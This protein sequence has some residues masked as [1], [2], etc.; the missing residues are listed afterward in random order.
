MMIDQDRYY[1]RERWGEPHGQNSDAYKDFYYQDGLMDLYK[2]AEGGAVEFYHSYIELAFHP[3]VEFGWGPGGFR[4]DTGAAKGR[5][6]LEAVTH[7]IRN[8]NPQT[9]A[10]MG[11]QIPTLGQEAR[12]RPFAQAWRALP[13]TDPRPVAASV[14][15][16]LDRAW[17]R[18]FGD[19]IAVVNDQVRPET[20][21][22]TLID[23]VPDG[24]QLVDVVNGEVFVSASADDRKSFT[25]NMREFDLRTLE[26]R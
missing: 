7:A 18:A 17:V 26:V 19:R 11:W 8:G 9:L 13:F 21:A 3:D 20:I 24:K 5:Y 2:T 22:V 10:Q 14:T 15:P 16:A 4:T 23:P 25:I 6:F 1:T 12:L